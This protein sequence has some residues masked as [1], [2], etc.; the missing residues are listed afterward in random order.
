MPD[1]DALRPDGTRTGFTTLPNSM[2]RCETERRLSLGNLLL[3]TVLYAS[4]PS[5]WMT[6]LPGF[7]RL[8]MPLSMTSCSLTGGGHD[9]GSKSLGGR[10]WTK[11]RPQP[12]LRRPMART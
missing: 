8:R 9:F 1:D 11:T 4:A 3:I 7:A 10:K 6:Q 12:R 5:P 2:L